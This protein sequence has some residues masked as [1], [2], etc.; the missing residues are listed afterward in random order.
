MGKTPTINAIALLL[1][2]QIADF[3][4]WIHTASYA[5]G[6][7]CVSRMILFS[8]VPQRIANIN[9]TPTFLVNKYSMLLFLNKQSLP[10]I[11]LFSVRTDS[12]PIQ[13]LQSR[14]RFFF[15]HKRDDAKFIT[16][17][18]SRFHFSVWFN[19]KLCTFVLI[20]RFLIDVSGIG[21]TNSISLLLLRSSLLKFL[22]L[23]LI[24][25]RHV[26]L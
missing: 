5:N 24:F 6:L 23:P 4:C 7:E 3:Y 10:I 9:I 19:M 2:W 13:Y 20:G 21:F 8:V 16:S 17:L 11:C 26:F 1:N 22:M 18:D 15:F 14:Q 12:I 25:D